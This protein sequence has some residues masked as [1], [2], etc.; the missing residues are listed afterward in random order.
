MRFAP[1]FLLAAALAAPMLGGCTAIRDHQGYIADDQLMAASS[2]A[3][4]IANRSSARSAGDLHRQFD[5]HDGI[6]S[7]PDPAARLPASARGEQTVLRG[8]FDDAG[9]SP[10]SSAPHGSWCRARSVQRDDADARPR[11]QL[12]RRDFGNI[13]AS[14][15]ASAARTKTIPK[16]WIHPHRR[17]G[18]GPC[19]DGGG[20]RAHAAEP[21][22]LICDILRLYPPPPFGGPPPPCRAWGGISG[23]FAR[24]EHGK[25]DQVAAVAV[26]GAIW[27]C[28]ACRPAPAR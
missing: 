8:R 6:M 20:I 1:T 19:E 27:I 5:Q 10:A 26:I 14:A 23:R 22:R 2:P 13:G 15:P 4:T 28:C 12:L 9:M 17:W 18:G 3:S 11:A 7:R 25:R 21:T 24:S 16:G